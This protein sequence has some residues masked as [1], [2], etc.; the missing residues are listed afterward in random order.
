MLKRKSNSNRPSKRLKQ[1]CALLESDPLNASVDFTT[2]ETL[3]ALVRILPQNA[4]VQ[5]EYASLLDRPIESLKYFQAAV[6]L[7]PKCAE[8]HFGLAQCLRASRYDTTCKCHN[9][10]CVRSHM[11]LAYDL[12]PKNPDYIVAYANQMR[13]LSYQEQNLKIE[14]L[15]EALAIDEDHYGAITKLLS[16]DEIWTSRDID[17][18]LKKVAAARICAEKALKDLK[19]AYLPS[20]RREKARMHD[21]IAVCAEKQQ[22]IVMAR[23]HYDLAL[24]TEPNE[25]P[26]NYHRFLKGRPQY[27]ALY[28]IVVKMKR[29][30]SVKEE[31][32][33]AA[34][35]DRY[36]ILT[37]GYRALLKKNNPTA[38][39]LM[40]QYAQ[41]EVQW[42]LLI[43]P[44][45][46]EMFPKV[47]TKAIMDFLF[48]I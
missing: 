42:I 12:S 11:K 36:A 48:H 17:V 14:K 33:V 30:F 40:K 46:D 4:R 37:P 31:V 5:F 45:N 34:F 23:K 44:F 38:L 9:V 47:V 35:F 13:Q 29:S 8:F 1:I 16:F 27:E 43:P 6:D 41:R 7:D 39:I 10:L 32:S 15:M 25:K 2:A 21:I 3:E 26:R 19:G 28:N 24:L 22:D 18:D 20:T